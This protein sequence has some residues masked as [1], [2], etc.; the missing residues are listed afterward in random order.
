MLPPLQLASEPWQIFQ[1]LGAAAQARGERALVFYNPCMGMWFDCCN[2][3][4]LSHRQS[5]MGCA[6]SVALLARRRLIV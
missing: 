5:N 4:G 3:T 2:N 1:R 6:V